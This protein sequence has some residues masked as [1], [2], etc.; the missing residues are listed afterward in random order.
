MILIVHLTFIN[1]LTYLTFGIGL[2]KIA[3]TRKSG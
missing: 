1:F 2:N 3:Q